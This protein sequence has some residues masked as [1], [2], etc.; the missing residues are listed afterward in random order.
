MRF[1][2][3][4]TGDFPFC[5]IG[6]VTIPKRVLM[7]HEM[8]RNFPHPFHLQIGSS[9]KFFQISSCPTSAVSSLQVF[10]LK[11]NDTMVVRLFKSGALHLLY[12][13]EWVKGG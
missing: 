9:V 10:E 6:V 12:N 4:L 5:Y 7:L 8:F 11:V 13:L 3:T 1:C 2:G